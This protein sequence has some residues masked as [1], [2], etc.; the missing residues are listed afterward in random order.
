M[1]QNFDFKLNYYFNIYKDTTCLS[2]SKFKDTFTRKHGKFEYLNELVV[3]IQRYQYKKYG[4][5]VQS[6]KSLYNGAL[7]NQFNTLEHQRVYDR[8]GT[9]EERLRRKLKEKW[10]TMK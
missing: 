8:F 5:L 9:K 4:N 3:M 7:T 2:V 6:G 1:K 10:E